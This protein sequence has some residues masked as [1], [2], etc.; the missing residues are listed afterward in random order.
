MNKATSSASEK[1]I[2]CKK[3]VESNKRFAG[4]LQYKRTR[5]QKL[6]IALFDDKEVCLSCRYYEEKERIDWKLKKNN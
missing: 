4:T 2:F 6:D 5:D 1:I 3:C